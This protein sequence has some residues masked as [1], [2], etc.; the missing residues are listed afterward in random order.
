MNKL[1][2][3][4]AIIGLTYSLPTLAEQATEY[5]HI[6]ELKRTYNVKPSQWPAAITATNQKP[7]E[8]A[9]LVNTKPLASKSTIALGKALFND[10]I[11]SRD[12]T[13]SCSSCHEERFK[14]SDRR[15]SAIGIDDQIGSRNSPAIFGID[16]WQSFFWDGRAKTAEQQAL[17]P[18]ENPI[19]MDLKID[20]ALERLNSSPKYQQLFKQVYQTTTITKTHL[21]KAIVAFER[22]IDAP[23][24]KF[25]RFIS[26]AYKTPRQAVAMLSDDEL[27]GLNLFRTKAKCMTCHQGALLSDNKLHSTGLH[28]YGRRFQDLGLYEVTH[29]IV[30][31]GKFRTPSLLGIKHTAPWMHNGLFTQL[32]GLVAGYNGGGFRPKRKKSQLNDPLFPETTNDLHK[33]HLTKQEIKQLVTFLEIL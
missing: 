19:E 30:D 4:L 16:H 11:L 31:V 9:P 1:I 6:S 28:N 25:Q 7:Q 29:N 13:V 33:L 23:D 24:T 18:I 2:K 3:S 10:P 20:V 26:V 8:M 32:N 5:S 22:T 14:F 17:M 12:N 15:R 27:I 21:A